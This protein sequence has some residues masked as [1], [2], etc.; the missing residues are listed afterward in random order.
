LRIGIVGLGLIGTSIALAAR[1]AWPDAELVGVDRAEVICHPRVIE[2]FTVAGTE[3]SAVADSDV[4]MLATPVSAIVDM[5][6]KLAAMSTAGMIMDTGSTKRAI[7]AAA[8]RAGLQSFVGGHPMAGS[9]HSGPDAARSDLFDT[10]AWFLVGTPASVVAAGAVVQKLGSTPIFM[11]DD[12][13]EHDRVMAAVSHLP[14]VVATALMSRVGE[15]VGQDGL[16]YAGA[17]LRDTTRLAESAASVWE[18]V[19]ATNADT[20]RPLLLTLADD[21][22][23]IAGDL[24]DSA[25]VRRLFGTANMYRCELTGR[26]SS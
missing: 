17:G 14:Q 13:T 20:L 15:A 23:Q 8:G 3:L 10:R 1:R 25:A 2:A 12:G 26:S 9:E 5:L 4:I 11:V 18:S 22:R 16:A 19:L 6:P 7:V 21:L 24:N